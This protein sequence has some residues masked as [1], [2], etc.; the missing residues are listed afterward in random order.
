MLGMLGMI[1]SNSYLLTGERL[2]GRHKRKGSKAGE[3]ALCIPELHVLLR[4][5]PPALW[6]S[7][8]YVVERPKTYHCSSAPS[9]SVCRDKFMANP[10]PGKNSLENTFVHMLQLLPWWGKSSKM[11]CEQVNLCSRRILQFHTLNSLP[12]ACRHHYPGW[13]RNMHAFGPQNIKDTINHWFPLACIDPLLMTF[14]CLPLPC[15]LLIYQWPEQ[16]RDVG[17]QLFSRGS[18][19]DNGELLLSR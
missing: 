5:L 11:A 13:E 14:P 7:M 8:V 17:W 19:W 6:T 12:G 10:T 18:P 9:L 1:R 15:L 2:T 16:T 3:Q 4:H